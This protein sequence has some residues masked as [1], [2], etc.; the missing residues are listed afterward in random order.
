MRRSNMKRSTKKNYLYNA[1][2]EI[3]ETYRYPIPVHQQ[4]N[5]Y[6][7]KPMTNGIKA[8]KTAMKPFSAEKR[9]LRNPISSPYHLKDAT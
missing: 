1:H 6:G 9:Q 2:E 5:S 3:Q 4:A 8:F 7:A